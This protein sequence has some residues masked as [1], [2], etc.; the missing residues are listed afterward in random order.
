MEHKVRLTCVFLIKVFFPPVDIQHT[1]CP[2]RFV[3]LER[4]LRKALYSNIIRDRHIH[5][6]YLEQATRHI[7]YT[8]ASDIQTVLLEH[9]GGILGIINVASLH[10]LSI[11]NLFSVFT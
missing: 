5:R 6:E 3:I 10:Q 8:H 1:Q 4:Q 11:V 7:R 9:G 2:C